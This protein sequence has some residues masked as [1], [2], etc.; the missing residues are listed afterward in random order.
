MISRFPA[1]D[2][3]FARTA[4]PIPA[5]TIRKSMA[6][7]NFLERSFLKDFQPWA[8]TDELGQERSFVFG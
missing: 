4:P 5:P 8:S 2:N 1:R 7:V 6:M 3:R